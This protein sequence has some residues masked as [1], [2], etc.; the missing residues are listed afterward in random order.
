MKAMR[1]DKY[2]RPGVDFAMTQVDELAKQ[3]RVTTERMANVCSVDMETWN[4]HSNAALSCADALENQAAELTR[5]REQ[6]E[7]SVGLRQRLALAEEIAASL[8]A[9]NER[10][11]KA[12]ENWQ[13]WWAL[14]R[15]DKRPDVGSLNYMKGQKALAAHVGEEKPRS[16]DDFTDL[17][18]V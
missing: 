8:S 12:L 13:E 7:A 2:L 9:E 18:H 4:E 1:D 5:L 17:G 11:R 15:Q 10:L 14:P 6:C 3:L 16:L